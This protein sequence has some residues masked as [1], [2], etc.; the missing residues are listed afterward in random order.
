MASID[1]LSGLISA[2]VQQ[3]DE[4][5]VSVEGS[6]AH[7]EEL[8]S[9]FQ[10]MNADSQANGV[11]EVKRLLEE[12]QGQQA[13]VKAKLEEARNAAEA[14]K[15]NGL[16]PG[17]SAPPQWSGGL[18]G[19]GHIRPHPVA[20]ENLR[21]FGWPKR[22]D[23]TLARGHLY[24]GAGRR[25]DGTDV[26]T[27]HRK[28]HAPPCDDLR[29]PWRSDSGYTTT[30]H[31]E[32]DAAKAM[33]ERGLKEAVLY[34]NI[35]PCGRRDQDAKR[36]DANLRKVIPKGANLWV[37]TIRENSSPRLTRYEGTGEAIV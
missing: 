29:E 34:L 2:D 31:A 20:I 32:R 8:A 19:F 10:S 23:T 33:R 26:M 16:Q 3:S 6:K 18:D 11:E 13:A 30:W 7:A 4:T 27:A 37:W 24:D 12:A 17:G 21:R 9:Q 5:H 1:E 14:L 35:P 25:I 28:G 22:G 15:G 36:C